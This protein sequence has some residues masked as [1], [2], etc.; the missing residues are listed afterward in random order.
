VA[1]HLPQLLV[2]AKEAVEVAEAGDLLGEVR[3][4]HDRTLTLLSEAEQGGRK[5]RKDAL[6]AI[7]EARSNLELVGRLTKEL[8]SSPT[9]NIMIA[10]QVQ[11]V[12]L[13]AL[14]SYPEARLAVASAIGELRGAS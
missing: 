9:V 14:A 10:P 13:S 7:R 2:K 5:D 8:D 3:D 12:I 1:D 4:L 6:A 11:Q